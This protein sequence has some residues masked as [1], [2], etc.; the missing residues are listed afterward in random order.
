MINPWP[1]CVALFQIPTTRKLIGSCSCLVFFRRPASWRWVL[2]VGSEYTTGNS[3]CSVNWCYSC[4]HKCFS[5]TYTHMPRKQTDNELSKLKAI[6]EMITQTEAGEYDSVQ[7]ALLQDL[8]ARVRERRETQSICIQE[9]VHFIL[10]IEEN[11]K[12]NNLVCAKRSH[13]RWRRQ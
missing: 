6:N 4:V 8:N 5:N 1:V 2:C 7:L 11:T 9:A 13:R 12:I 3:Y 10:T